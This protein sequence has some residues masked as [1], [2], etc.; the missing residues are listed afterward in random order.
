MNFEELLRKAGE[1]GYVEQV[2]HPVVYAEGLPEARVG[3]LV[4]FESGSNGQVTALLEDSVQILTF[5]TEPVKIG[6][7]IAR[8]GEIL[9]VPVGEDLFGKVIDPLGRIMWGGDISLKETRPV[10]AEAGGIETRWRTTKPLKTG[11]AAV[12]ILVP[13]GKGQ[14]ELLM[15]GSNTGKSSLAYQITVNQAREGTVCIYAAIGKKMASIKRMEE[16]FSQ[17]KV[18]DRVIVVASASED[19]PAIVFL[20]PFTA[21]TIAEY[22]RDKGRDVLIVLDDLSTH[23]KF[24]RE[25]ALLGGSFP[26]RE[27][28]PGDIFHVH[29][30]LLERAGNFLCGKNE[31]AITCLPVVNMPGKKFGYIQ[32]NLISITDGHIYFDSDLFAEGRR[33]AISPYLS[34]TRI[35]HQA[36]TRAEQEISRQ[37]LSFLNHWQKMQAFVRFGAELTPQIRETL[38][39]GEKIIQFFNQ[40]LHIL[41]SASLQVFLFTMVWEDVWR[42]KSPEEMREELDKIVDLYAKQKKIKHLIDKVVQKAQSWEDLRKDVRK[43][44]PGILA[45]IRLKRRRLNHG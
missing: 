25:I 15:G 29:A 20:A 41:L 32:T 30:S 14:R 16:Y 23:A 24:Y 3:E 9:K 19:S 12:D 17:Q 42:N 21:M 13:I 7:R 38:D 18:R 22:F 31:V 39:K 26:G 6:E 43:E 45:E 10:Y 40:P 35:G 8:T 28:Y 11:V 2:M 1:V 27:S 33:P 37:T 44:M 4:Q 5:G 34:V 36:Q